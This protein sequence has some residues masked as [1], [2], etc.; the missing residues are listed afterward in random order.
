MMLDDAG[1]SPEDITRISDKVRFQVDSSEKG[2]IA[3]A[4]WRLDL[5]ETHREKLYNKAGVQREVG[6]ED[7]LENDAEQLFGQYTH[8]VIASGYMEDFLKEFRVRD[9]EGNLPVHA[10][11][12]DTVKAYIAKEAQAKGMSER[13][14]QKEMKVLDHTY[15]LINGIPI[16]GAS[17]FRAAQRMLRDYNFSR[18]GGQLGVAQLA[19]IG[20]LIGNGGM[21]V[22]LQN[23]PALRRIFTTAKDGKFSDEF[24]NEIEA[25]WGFGTDLTRMNMAPIFDEG[26]AAEAATNWQRVDHGLQR[27]KQIT[28]V[29]SGMAHVNMVLQRMNARV[30]VQRFMDDATGVRGI[31]AKRLRVMGISE[32][33]HPRIQE[34]LRKHVD[35]STGMLGKQVNRLN[36]HKWDDLDA[37]NAF[38]N[39]VDRWAKKSV[40]ENDIGNMPDF[41]SYELGKTI[42]QFRSFMMAAYVK[43]TLAALHVRDWEVAS[44]FLTSMFFGGLFYVGQTY[45]NSI[46]RE[47]REEFLEDRLSPEKLPNAAFQ[48]AAFSSVIPMAADAVLNTVGIDPV[49][50]FRSSGLQSGGLTLT[51]LALSNP[52]G[53][54]VDGTVRAFG[55][56]T[57]GLFN[58]DYDFSEQDFKAA[59]KVLVFQ[60]MFGVRNVL[61][62]IGG[63][64]PKYSQ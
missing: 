21:R 47:D 10:P 13:Q 59:A 11:S 12:F 54:L 23:L 19:E 31:N 51:E 60:N 20:N 61:A 33:L 44:A 56:I 63:T 18:I 36:I 45:V 40:Q 41:M 62:A 43:Q 7:F 32:E 15:K 3:S 22:L 16:E 9:A 28:A 6:I 37:K 27:A 39:G 26:G 53:D 5:D 49:F 57:Q 52:S 46:G 17:S 35:Q 30:L 50:D 42:G 38:I 29:G 58:P 48:R 2:R 34:Q 64:L 1:M 14:F 8:S 4:K 25:I 24:L 55:G